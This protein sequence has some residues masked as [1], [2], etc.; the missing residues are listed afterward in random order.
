MKTRIFTGIALGIVIIG[1]LFVGGPILALALT[2]I[3]L[4]GL[5]EF[6]A[7]VKGKV[8]PIASIS[9]LGAL[10]YFAI[11]YFKGVGTLSFYYLIAVVLVLFIIMVIVYP[12]YSTLDIST[13]LF[14]IIYIPIMLS[15]IYLVRETPH[16]LYLVWF[17]F[18][19]AWSNDTFAYFVGSFMGSKK[20]T[21][22]LSPNK[23]VEGFIGGVFG[24]I[25]M[26]L[27]FGLLINRVFMIDIPN[28]TILATLIGLFGAILGTLGDLAGSA[29]K[30]QFG[31]KD[32]GKL[33]PGHGG[34][35]D[36]F[37]SVL[38]TGPMVY[39]IISLM[40]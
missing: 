21:P 24:S 33:L 40:L 16:G 6:N 34:I 22:K 7:A 13:T 29:I 11:V 18:L 3:S 9:S 15:N 20:M 8:K 36:R 32:F 2:A 35:L 14:G 17:I 10:G 39:I 38:F 23:T 30:R 28:I 5:F 12:K 4:V 25:V 27:L 37:D 19:S 26:C 31:V 1:L